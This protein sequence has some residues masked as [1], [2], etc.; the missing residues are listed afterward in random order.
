MI[1][2]VRER[3]LPGAEGGPIGTSSS[4]RTRHGSGESSVSESSVPEVEFRI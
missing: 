4:S 1:T 3:P 2:C